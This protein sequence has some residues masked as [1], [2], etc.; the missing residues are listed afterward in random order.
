MV[1]RLA[2]GCQDHTLGSATVAIYDTAWVSMISRDN[3]WVFP[4]CFQFILDSQSTSGGWDFESSCEDSILNTLASLLALVRHRTIPSHDT[5]ES[6][7]DID[8][9]VAKAKVYLEANLRIWDI[10]AT[11]NVGFEILFPALL[12]LLESEHIWFDFPARKALERLS[13]T[14]LS[15]FNAE[16]FYKNPNALLHSLE[17][18]IGRIDFD[19]L[20]DHKV[21][22]SMMGSP[23][24]TAAYLIYSSVWDSEAEQY[25]RVVV[26]DGSGLGKG[27]VPSVYPMPVFESTWV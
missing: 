6:F 27:G 9:R 25:I 13:S 17:G 19:R 10:E 11:M 18:L 26:Q 12:S 24:S 1:E 3:E 7:T 15:G 2:N 14:K 4:E 5:R 16:I 8:S 20:S 21:S 22:G 23:A